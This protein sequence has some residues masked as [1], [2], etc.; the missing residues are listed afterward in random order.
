MSVENAIQSI[1]KTFATGRKSR[2]ANARRN[3][4][5]QAVESLEARAL[6]TLIGTSTVLG[7]TIQTSDGGGEQSF[8][9]TGTAIVVDNSTDPEFVSFSGAYDIDIDAN[10]ISMKFN[11]SGAPISVPPGT[12]ADG[13]FDRYYFAFDLASNESISA[14]SASANA[15]LQPNVSVSGNTVVVEIAPGMEVGPG[16]DALIDVNI[17]RSGTVITGRKF[18][19]VDNDGERDFSER[20][21]NGFTVEIRDLESNAIISTTTGNVD[22]NGDGQIDPETESG[23]YV[24][25]DVDAGTY[26]VQEVLPEGWVQSLPNN[27]DVFTA[28]ELD[29]SLNLTTTGDDFANWGGLNEKWFFGLMADASGEMQTQWFYITPDGSI[30]QWDGSPRTALTGTLVEQLGT[31]YYDDPALIYNAQ[32][33][34]Q[35]IADVD[36]SIPQ[37]FR[38]FDFGNHLA[39][40]DFTVITNQETNEATINWDAAAGATYDVWISDIAAGQQIQFVPDL[41]GENIPLITELPDRRYRVWIRT[42]SLGASSAWS[43]PQ[44]FEFFRDPVNLITSDRATTIDAT[45]TIEWRPLAGANSYDIRV[46]NGDEVVYLENDL[47]TLSHRVATQLQMQVDYRVAVRANFADGSQTAWDE[48]LPIRIDGRTTATLTGNVLNW[49]PIPDATEYEIWVNSFDNDGNLVQSQ[50][51]SAM[52][53]DQTSFT[54]P[55]LERGDYAV[56]VRGIRS[57]DDD[58]YFSSW[59]PRVDFF[60]TENSQPTDDE[61]TLLALDTIVASLQTNGAPQEAVV[62]PEA[63]VAAEPTESSDE[64]VE[65]QGIT[66]VMVELSSSDLLHKT[67]I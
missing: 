67:Q 57:E 56:W 1:L 16:F 6:L 10:T 18:N 25:S 54:L 52:A 65:A 63:P 39:P 41:D 53:V 28:F 23:I 33:P 8:G 60:V 21:L 5:T 2:R 9:P 20:W 15:S 32:S 42:N 24:F 46:T 66:A 38:G 49:A 40:T 55:D 35:Y 61:S 59:S 44:Q 26:V 19:D 13:T 12:V 3:P 22:L 45:P 30:F 4:A 7:N 64:V 47:T 48:G 29:S 11:A 62:E 43:K 51:V 27:P 14:V 31:E 58:R 50:I 34:R 17:S 36:V 37:T